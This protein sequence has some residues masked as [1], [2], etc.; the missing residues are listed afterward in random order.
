MY[1]VR[2]CKHARERVCKCLCVYVFVCVFVCACVFIKGGEL[3]A[4]SKL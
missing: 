1:S 4:V 2:A 3:S